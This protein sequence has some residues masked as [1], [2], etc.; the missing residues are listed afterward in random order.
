MAAMAALLLFLAALPARAQ[1]IDIAA[2]FGTW[3]GSALSESAISVYFELTNR[4]IGV[5]VRPTADGF[6]LG[7]M[8]VQRQKGNPSD[9]KEELKQ[10]SIDFRRLRDGV[11]AGSANAD[12][13][14]SGAP[15][16]WARIDRQTL[17]VNVLQITE[18]GR[19]EL[20]VY[21]RTLTGGF[22][23]LEFSRLMDGR[24]VRT[25]KGRLVKVAE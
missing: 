6:S 17:V 11:W 16:A 4:D 10:T 20:Q 12:P 22:M 25:A 1:N 2:F 18:D 14:A 9:P 5:Q 7:W 8:T 15:Y 3:E 13:L 23:E 19:P 24:E 21:R